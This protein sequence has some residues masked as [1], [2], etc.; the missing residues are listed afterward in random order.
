MLFD[1][2]GWKEL[3]RCARVHGYIEAEKFIVSVIHLLEDN[4]TE[5]KGCSQPSI[6]AKEE[7]HRLS[8]GRTWRSRDRMVLR[9][10]LSPFFSKKK[11]H[12]N[13]ISITLTWRDSSVP[14]DVR[15][16][17]KARQTDWEEH[18]PKVLA[19]WGNL[20]Q[21]KKILTCCRWF[22]GGGA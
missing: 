18:R 16:A 4:K 13:K 12:W 17:G 20:W 22:L 14:T 7:N 11:K 8:E 5:R 21:K 6:H 9:N 10:N 15:E 3:E 19:R 2:L 1:D